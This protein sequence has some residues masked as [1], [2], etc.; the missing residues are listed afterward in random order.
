MKRA[1]AGI[2]LKENLEH[3]YRELVKNTS[4][5]I[6][7]MQC[8]LSIPASALAYTST[9]RSTPRLDGLPLAILQLEIVSCP[10]PAR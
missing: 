7:L 5:T 3:L 9:R 2:H 1:F 6:Y 10:L 8:H 4:A